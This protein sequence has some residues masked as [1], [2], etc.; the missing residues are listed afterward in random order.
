[1]KPVKLWYQGQSYL[2]HRRV[3]AVYHTILRAAYPMA[4]SIEDADIVILHV[5][6]HDYRSVYALHPNMRAKYVISYCVWEASHLPTTYRRS[7]DMVQEVWTCSRY[8]HNVIAGEGY[9]TYVIPH[10]TCRGEAVSDAELATVKSLIGYDSQFIF[11]WIGRNIG[12][13]KNAQQLLRCFEAI[14]ERVP[15]A[16]LIMK[17]MPGEPTFDCSNSHVIQLQV[18]LTDGEIN[19]LYYLADAYV[20]PHHAEGWGLTLSDAM[21]LNV[22]VIATGY[23][24]NL[25]FM[26]H[27]NAFL[28]R[29][30]ESYI[31]RAELWGPFTTDMKWGYPDMEQ[32]EATMIDLYDGELTDEVSRKASIAASDVR[33]YSP[34]TIEAALRGRIDRI[35]ETRFT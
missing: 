6:P 1:M 23:S 11:L 29:A 16:R 22:P 13:R 17:T 35:I 21:L 28:L 26:T 8:C 9:P 5:E 18:T 25:D 24:G 32:L 27:D 30:G 4:A 14:S 20:S 12:Y 15:K 10:S 33:R 2:S 34:A 19:A 7:L 3:G 31:D